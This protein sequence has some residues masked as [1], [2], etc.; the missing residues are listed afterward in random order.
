ML[1]RE[2]IL[3]GPCT[4]DVREVYRPGD[5]CAGSI[6]W[7]DLRAIYRVKYLVSRAVRPGR[8][9]EIGVRAGYSAA[10]FLAARPTAH[11]VGLDK[12][13]GSHGGVE[14][15]LQDAR[16]M[17]LGRYPDAGVELYRGD[18][19]DEGVRRGLAA[20]CA[21]AF[22]LVHVDGDH[23]EA[24]CAA[25]LAWGA[26]LLRPGG[27]VLVDDYGSLEEVRRA[28]DAFAGE[29]G[30][31][32]VYLPSPHGELLLRRPPGAGD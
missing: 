6:G 4:F 18:S 29:T 19:G 10:A 31:E 25:D 11:Y 23:S 24:G 2:E 15:Y 12:D 28:A 14:G 17:L 21:G 26:S 1:T 30:W 7:C 5:P 32:C 22:D 3:A 9:L 27:Y 8:I 13:D 20:R 16:E